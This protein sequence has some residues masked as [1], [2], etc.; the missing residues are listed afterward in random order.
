MEWPSPKAEACTNGPPAALRLPPA[1]N[2]LI[3][4]SQSVCFSKNAMLPVGPEYWCALIPL[5]VLDLSQA[6]V[7]DVKDHRLWQIASSHPTGALGPF[8]GHCREFHLFSPAHHSG[9]ALAN[10]RADC[11]IVLLLL[12]FKLAKPRSLLLLKG[13]KTPSRR[14]GHVANR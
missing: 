3:R 9:E 12:E 2:D 10:L 13:A 8:R 4:R 14:P 11:V 6:S 5:A 1:L 7:N